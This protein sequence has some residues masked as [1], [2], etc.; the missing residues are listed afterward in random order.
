MPPA[1]SDH[2]DAIR[3]GRQQFGASVAA[4]NE[5]IVTATESLHHVMESFDTGLTSG[6]V[7]VD[8]AY[9][10][11]NLDVDV[12]YDGQP[13]VLVNT[14]PDRETFLNDPTGMAQ[15]SGWLLSERTDRMRVKTVG[16]RSHL[17]LRLAT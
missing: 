1:G 16:E 5:T 7:T 17:L 8:L 6:S 14:R 13:I 12:S 9:D 2:D 4:R 11:Y 3:E 10:E 15:L